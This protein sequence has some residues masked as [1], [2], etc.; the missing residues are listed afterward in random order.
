MFRFMYSTVGK[1]PLMAQKAFKPSC[2]GVDYSQPDLAT[3]SDTDSDIDTNVMSPVQGDKDTA[4]DCA[5]PT[6]WLSLAH[7]PQ[8]PVNG[9]TAAR[10]GAEA[11]LLPAPAPASTKGSP[12]GALDA[13]GPRGLELR[14]AERR[15]ACTD[16]S[17][18]LGQPR[19]KG[20]R[21]ADKDVEQMQRLLSELSEACCSMLDALRNTDDS[22]KVNVGTLLD[23]LHAAGPPP[24]KRCPGSVTAALAEG[25]M[26]I[27][28]LEGKVHTMLAA[29]QTNSAGAML[30][31]GADSTGAPRGVEPARVASDS[32]SWVSPLKLAETSAALPAGA[33]ALDGHTAEGQ[34]SAGDAAAVAPQGA[35]RAAGPPSSAAYL[36]L[37]RRKSPLKFPA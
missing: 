33:K 9:A 3:D 21:L 34:G 36:L 10:G 2:Y 28:S 20:A 15:V 1:A 18:F 37:Q 35:Q 27:A 22:V 8:S 4:S 29:W 17:Q 23:N 5:R 12:A 30:K 25:V 24:A 16:F 7:A 14:L 19:P 26:Q 13:E 11:R 6:G 32:Q 31:A